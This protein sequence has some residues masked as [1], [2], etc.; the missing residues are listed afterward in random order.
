MGSCW[1]QGLGWQT[2]TCLVGPSAVGTL[3]ALRDL[4][5]PDAR[6]CWAESWDLGQRLLIPPTRAGRGLR[7]VK[8]PCWRHVLWRGGLHLLPWLE[9]TGQPAAQTG[10]W[11]VGK[12]LCLPACSHFDVLPLA[13]PGGQTS[14]LTYTPPRPFLCTQTPH[15]LAPSGYLSLEFVLLILLTAPVI[16]LYLAVHT[17]HGSQGTS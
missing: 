2:Q 7:Q 1:C 17:V 12:S 3:A 15:P 5:Q 14:R 8:G 16:S 6:K 11:G 13:C 4:R 10:F 9:R